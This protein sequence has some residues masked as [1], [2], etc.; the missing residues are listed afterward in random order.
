[1]DIAVVE[2]AVNKGD[3]TFDTPVDTALPIVPANKLEFKD[4]D[5][6]GTPDLVIADNA[7]N[8]V[9][10]LLPRA[11]GS[12]NDPV[13]IATGDF[14]DLSEGLE[15]FDLGDVDGD[16]ALDLIVGGVFNDEANLILDQP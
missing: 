15:T 1:T 3:G 6:D 10:A 14:A 13:A 16:Q 5:G 12:L 11:D 4:L 9:L 2:D 7:A 8:Q